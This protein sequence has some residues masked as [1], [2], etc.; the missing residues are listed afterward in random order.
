MVDEDLPVALPAL[1]PILAHSFRLNK[2][3]SLK[4]A[5]WERVLKSQILHQKCRRVRVDDWLWMA[6]EESFPISSIDLRRGGVM[7]EKHLNAVREFFV[8]PPHHEIDKQ[9]VREC[10]QFA[11]NKIGVGLTFALC[12]LT[13]QCLQRVDRMLDQVRESPTRQFAVSLLNCQELSAQHL[14]TLVNIIKKNGELFQS[15]KMMFMNLV[16]K[17]RTKEVLRE[18]RTVI[19]ASCVTKLRRLDICWNNL[20]VDHVAAVCSSMRYGCQVE[21]INLSYIMLKLEV[22]PH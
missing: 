2:F 11:P 13:P 8:T 20:L 4:K 3:P 9:F 7:T 22:S 5:F 19:A 12:K 14:V 1:V 6:E 16:K 17:E 10:E 21:S 18:L 15:A